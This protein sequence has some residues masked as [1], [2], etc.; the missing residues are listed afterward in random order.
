MNE[1]K[2]LLAKIKKYDFAIKELNLYL[3]THPNCRRALS[4]YSSYVKLR[5]EA[6]S[7]FTENFGPLTPDMNNDPQNWNWISD[8]WPWERS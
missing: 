5:K 6:V 7:E 3:D 2:M 8:P 4:L 1:R